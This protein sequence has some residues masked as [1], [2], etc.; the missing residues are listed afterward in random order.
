MPLDYLEAREAHRQKRVKLDQKESGSYLGGSTSFLSLKAELSHHKDDTQNAPTPRKYKSKA[1]S[2]EFVTQPDKSSSSQKTT[3][4][5]SWSKTPSAQLERDR[6][7]ALERKSKLYDELKSGQH[8]NSLRD[9]D[10]QEGGR[11]DGM[12]IVDWDAKRNDTEDED[13]DSEDKIEYTD[14]LGRTRLVARSEVPLDYLMNL[15]HQQEQ[16]DQEATAIYGP[17]SHFPV[18][19]PRIHTE[20]SAPVA[21][22]DASHEIRNRGAGFYQFS[23]DEEQRQ[24][25]MEQLEQERKRTEDI[26]SKADQLTVG[27]KRLQERRRFVEQKKRELNASDERGVLPVDAFLDDVAKD[28]LSNKT[29]EI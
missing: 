9:E 17:Q 16:Q 23:Q 11:Y 13:D 20:N 4:L 21:R 10:L 26:R 27:E 19:E 1:L 24:K 12:G 25:Q 2:S 14:E 8:R 6:L 18:F 28:W 29:K 7:E 3:T 15:K 5:S 22:F